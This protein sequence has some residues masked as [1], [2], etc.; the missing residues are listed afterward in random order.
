[1]PRRRLADPHRRLAPERLVLRSAVS[2]AV[3]NL[4]H[5]WL[6]CGHCMLLDRQLAPV[7]SLLRCEICKN[8]RTTPPT[9]GL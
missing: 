5:A 9:G 4:T 8:R 3:E 6:D 1:M 2:E 7:G